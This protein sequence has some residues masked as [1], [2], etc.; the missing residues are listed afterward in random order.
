MFDA[1]ILGIFVVPLG[2]KL[3]D[4]M[5]AV[6]LEHENRN[7]RIADLVF[8]VTLFLRIPNGE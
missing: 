3:G 5:R 2:H 7:V 4:V 8:A 1:A 6:F